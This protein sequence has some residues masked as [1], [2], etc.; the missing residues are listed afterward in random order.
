MYITN[1]S[2]VAKIAQSAGVDRIWV[3][4]EF[5]GKDVRQQGLDTVKSRHTVD[6][7]RRLR[8]V[9]SSS[10]LMVRINPIH[11]KSD[12]W[13]GTEAEIES[14]IDAGADVI[15]LPYFKTADEVKRFVDAVGCRTKT[16]I[17]VET[18]E[19]LEAI[20]EILQVPGVDEVH[21]G[22]N[23]LHLS[24]GKDF[25][26]ELLVDGTLD[27]LCNA[28][29]AH[30]VV[31][32]FGGIARVGYGMLP[33]ELIIAEHYQRGSSLAILSRGFCDANSVE[34]PEEIRGL[35]LEGVRNIRLRE[36]EVQRFSSDDFKS[37]HQMIVEKVHS[38]VEQIRQKRGQE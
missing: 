36:Q 20:H 34:D 12:E 3:D 15:M 28:F 4:M 13:P 2:D 8:K 19:A 26:F 37:N 11:E 18:K 24:Y 14:V 29:K 9:V 25:M 10:E 17:L 38:I 5:I 31:F 7:V 35:F 30:D 1:N 6:D 33:A 32:G 21:V 22:L 27:I 23:D 16:M